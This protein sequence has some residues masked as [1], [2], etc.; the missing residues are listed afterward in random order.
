LRHDAEFFAMLDDKF[1]SQE[2][3][4][5]VVL[6]RKFGR[7]TMTRFRRCISYLVQQNIIA[8]TNDPDYVLEWHLD[9]LRCLTS[10]DIE[11]INATL[12]QF[13]D[14]ILRRRERIKDRSRRTN[15]PVHPKSIES[16]VRSAHSLLRFV[17]EHHGVVSID[18]I[19]QHMLDLFVAQNARNRLSVAAFIKFVRKHASRTRKIRLLGQA[20]GF[21][22]ALLI[23]EERR[24]ELIREW[25]TVTTASDLRWGLLAL[26]SLI[27]GQSIIKAIRMKRDQIR[28]HG[29][30]YRIRFAKHEIDADPLL[31]PVIDR[32]LD[33]RREYST[34]ERDDSSPLLF[35]GLQAGTYAE[36][37][38]IMYFLDRYD[39]TRRQLMTTGLVTLIKSGIHQPKI[40]QDVF[41]ISRDTACK[42]VESFGSSASVRGTYVARNF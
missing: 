12:D 28:R 37:S 38:S 31:V 16:A 13:L 39:V 24:L 27:Y 32:W 18:M 3:I 21:R 41:G 34:F 1:E 33:M 23:S 2:A 9:R 26:F 20:R 29:D 42:Y 6:I 22:F 5:G 8:T 30:G 17:H 11:W 15:A 14:S 36:A 10:D 4:T 25:T 7:K 40:L 35:P 19:E